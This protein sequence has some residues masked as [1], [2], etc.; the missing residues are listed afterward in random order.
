MILFSRTG[1]SVVQHEGVTYR[2][3]PDGGFPF[4]DHVS[5]RLHRFA[6]RGVKQWETDIERQRR[7]MSE[8][9]DRRRDPAE[10]YAAVEKIVRAAEAGSQPE[11]KAEP[12]G[13]AKAAAS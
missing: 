10:L 4:P 9:M 13:R 8:E 1:A 6:V 2:P 3:G 12:K 11:A 7:V 5:D